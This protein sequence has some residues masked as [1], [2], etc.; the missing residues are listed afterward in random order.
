MGNSTTV[1]P[2]TGGKPQIVSR[3][4]E[5][6]KKQTITPG[7]LLKAGSI[8]VEALVRILNQMQAAA[9]D[10]TA[11]SRSDPLGTKCVLQSVTMIS[12]QQI[13]MV[14]TLGQ[15]WRYAFIIGAGPQA[16]NCILAKVASPSLPQ[17]KYCSVVPTGTGTYDVAIVAG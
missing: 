13:D 2:V 1:I 10:G 3:D 6:F 8:D 5:G 17:S 9:E 12:G 14:H 11:S 15:T 16:G 7:D 4:R